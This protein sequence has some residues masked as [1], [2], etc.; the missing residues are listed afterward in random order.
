MRLTLNWQALEHQLFDSAR[1]V[2]QAHLDQGEGPLYAAAF[3]ASYR[4]EEAVLS[5]PSFAANSLQALEE[6]DPDPQDQSFSS[7]KWNPADWQWDWDVGDYASAELIALDEPLQ[8]FA[9]RAGTGEWRGA[10]RRF[11][12]TVA[13]AARALGKHFSGHPGV[14]EDFVV[15]FHDFGGDIALAKRS[16]SRQQFETLFPVELEIENTLKH[17]ST[18]PL[19]GQAAFY[20]SRL[21]R[22]D[23]VSCE[24]AE[25]WLIAHGK[26]AQE[27]LLEQL[28]HHKEATSA[29]RILGLAGCSDPVVIDALRQQALHT[30]QPPLR[31]W[32]ATSLGYLGDFDWLIEQAADIAVSGFCANFGSFR[33]RGAYPPV[34]DHAPLRR[35]LEQRPELAA[36]VEEHLDEHDW[37]AIT[38]PKIPPHSSDG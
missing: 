35:L 37:R 20:L 38:C 1:Q 11:L 31:N 13:R 21:H 27:G 33:E 32:C 19:A 29:A 17:V 3:H 26:V 36:A 28:Q 14:T 4:E 10:E 24:V 6:N 34:L 18:L 2:L 16:I 12:V 7:L 30:H 25:P 22:F 23:G 8:A 15:I 9:T 5:L